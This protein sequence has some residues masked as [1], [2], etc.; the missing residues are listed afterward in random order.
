MER[1]RLRARVLHDSARH[2]QVDSGGARRSAI[3]RSIAG[4]SSAPTAWSSARCRRPATR[5]RSR[6]G[7]SASRRGSRSTPASTAARRPTRGLRAHDR[8]EIHQSQ[9]ALRGVARTKLTFSS[10]RNRE[11]VDRHGREPRR[12]RDLHRRLRRREPAAHHGEPAAEHHADLVA[13]RPR[14]LPTRRG[15]AGSRTSSSRA[16]IEG[17]MST[18]TKGTPNS[19]ELAADVLARRHAA[20]LHVESR[21]QFRDLRDE[22]RR[23]RRAAADQSPGDRHDADVVADR[24]RRSPSRRIA[25]GRRRST[26][27]APTAW[28]C[29]ASRSRQLAIAPTWSPAPFN[30]IAY[31]RAHR[32]GLRH[33]GLEPRGRRD[34]A[35]HVWRRQQREPGVG[36]QRTPSRVHVD[37]RGAQRRSSPSIATART[38]ARLRATGNNQHAALVAV[39][40]STARP[41]SDTLTRRIEGDSRDETQTQCS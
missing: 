26:S 7:C 16:S 23:Q 2:V 13:R 24:R 29:G 14:R 30:E 37:A 35:D 12:Q 22:S 25:A 27:S 38:C 41:R 31:T 33:Q 32:A 18:P 40:R 1:S 39:D 17:T 6:C 5:C 34:P 3:R 15:A 19:A 8:D 4:A 21:R 9:R 10:D 28:A 20:R 36:A 11:R